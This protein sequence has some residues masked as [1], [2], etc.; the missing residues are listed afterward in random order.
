[1]MQT[2]KS[3]YSALICDDRFYFRV[4]EAANIG[5]FASRDLFFEAFTK[6]ESFKGHKGMV[7]SFEDAAKHPS[8]FVY[9]ARVS[10]PKSPKSHDMFY[11]LLFGSISL[12]N[13]ACNKCSNCVPTDSSSKR[14]SKTNL[15]KVLQA[16]R[17]IKKDEQILIS[18]SC[19][20][21][22]KDIPCFL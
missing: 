10:L 7:I 21:E 2:F 1:M 18:Y 13:H 12:L 9:E 16:K 17:S 6:I 8:T 15:F 20:D 4:I 11:N 5:V 14:K 3:K 19:N 22:E